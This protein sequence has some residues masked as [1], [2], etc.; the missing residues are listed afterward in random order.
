VPA[1]LSLTDEPLLLAEAK[2]AAPRQRAAMVPRSRLD[3]ALE[4]G[5]DA[6]LTPVAA[7]RGYGK[8]TAVRAWSA[9]SGSALGVGSRAG[10]VARAEAAGLVAER[11]HPGDRCELA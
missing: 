10:A 7:P 1:G 8:T 11:D 3:Q 2:L 6:A 9:A 4:R 5:A